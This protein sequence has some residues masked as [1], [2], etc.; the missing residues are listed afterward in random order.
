MGTPGPAALDRWACTADGVQVQ[1]PHPHTLAATV[2][3]L[4]IIIV[5]D[6]F[7]DMD[8]FADG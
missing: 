2:I 8:K 4:I 7:M 1:G 5:V 3:V 6:K